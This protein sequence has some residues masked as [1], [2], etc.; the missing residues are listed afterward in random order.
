VAHK[1]F[2]NVCE[3]LPMRRRALLRT[4][5]GFSAGVGLAGCTALGRLGGCSEHRSAVIEAEPAN[6][7]A[8]YREH[9][10]PIRFVDLPED[11]TAIARAAIEDEHRECS[12]LSDALHSFVR[13]AATARERQ[14]TAYH[15]EVGEEPPFYLDVYYLRRGSAFYGLDMQVLDM[16]Y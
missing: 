10:V 1:T 9:I 8:E 13:R 12:P 5:G 3:I 14:Q 2:V 11:E 16:H 6:P 7:S 15:E 4:V